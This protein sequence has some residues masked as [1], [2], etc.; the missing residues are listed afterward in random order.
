[1]APV[2]RSLV[3]PRT[4]FAGLLA[5]VLLPTVASAQTPGSG[6]TPVATREA[7]QR[8]EEGKTLFSQ[9]RFGE[10][11]LK[12]EQACAVHRTVNCPKNLGLTEFELGQFVEATTHLREFLQSV[13]ASGPG[14]AGMDAEQVAQIQKRYTEAFMHCGHVEVTAPAGARIVVK[15]RIIGTAPLSDMIDVAVGEHVIEGHRDQGILRQSVT[16]AAGEVA[17]VRLADPNAAANT[18]TVQTRAN[19]DR[20]GSSSARTITLVSLYA[21]ALVAA[22]TGIGLTLHGEA[23]SNDAKDIRGRLPDGSNGCNG[24]TSTDCSDLR[25]LRDTYDSDRKWATVAFVGAGVFA[26]AATATFFL[27]HNPPRTRETGKNARGRDGRE[28]TNGAS[29]GQLVPL[30]APGVGGLGYV[31]SF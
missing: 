26:A 6:A 18:A 15:G 28:S 11:R 7:E 2:L 25:S 12:F 21:V 1:M 27:W 30:L 23:R 17:P 16:V 13:R 8:Y 22:G 20:P 14:A 31:G 3:S 29:T 5:S 9:R 4:L 10:A 19:T 24:V